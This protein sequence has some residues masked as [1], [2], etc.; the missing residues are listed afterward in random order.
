MVFS[1]E[2]SFQKNNINATVMDDSR[3]QWFGLEVPL[4][5]TAVYATVV[6]SRSIPNPKRGA[7]S[8]KLGWVQA[9]RRKGVVFSDD[10]SKAR[11]GVKNGLLWK[12]NASE[13][14]TGRRAWVLPESSIIDFLIP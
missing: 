1:K 2:K 13:K 14:D 3:E 12:S 6:S 9:L 11:L 8:Q 10:E 5:V 7:L 4:P